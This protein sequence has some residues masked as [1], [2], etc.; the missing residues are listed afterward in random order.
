LRR[1]WTT[2]ACA[3]A[4]SKAAYQ[5]LLTGAF[6]DPVVIRLPQGL[7]PAFALAHEK[8]GG[9]SATAG[10]VKDAGDDPDV[11]HGA[12]ILATVRHGESGTG[13]VFR[14]GEG[15][16]MVTRTGLPV[17]VGEP[18]INP[19]PRGQIAAAIADVTRVH[20]GGGDIEIAISIPGGA[21][22]AAKT[23]NGRLG[24]V[25]GLSILGTTGVVIPYSCASWIH[26]IHR[27]IDVARAA[28]IAHMA[29]STG[30]TSEA[31]VKQL[32]GLDDIALIDMG[33]FVGGMLKYL[34]RHPVPRLTIAGGFGKLAKLA[35]GALDL[36]SGASSVDVAV[37]ADAL[38]MLGAEAEI[39]ATARAAQ[40]ANEALVAAG[41][42]ARPL[43]DLIARRA[44]ATAL[45]TLAG[46]VAV[47]VV[48][49]DRRGVMIGRT[50]GEDDAR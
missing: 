45:A 40:S 37:L 5:A 10:I 32:Y 36:H 34:R 29:G 27:G 12:L 28:G 16:G 48:I 15:V 7:E 18:A 2:G 50:V 44:R 19:G 47:D 4:A 13:I 6:P 30:S 35:A 41:S 22:L 11:T 8:L 31:A 25:G 24:I 1:G 38:A 21:A 46:G 26:S 49:F 42:W 14:A 9:D 17:P 23:L 20:G 39:A 43:A 33:D 3:A